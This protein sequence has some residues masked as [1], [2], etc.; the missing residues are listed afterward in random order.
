MLKHGVAFAEAATCFQDQQALIL[1]DSAEGEARWS[2]LGFSDRARLLT[3]IFTAR[4]D[5]PRLISAR[6]A[7][8]RER[9]TY[10]RRV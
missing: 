3:V 9:D 1:E 2:L 6:K 4:G 8:A 5:K 10:A 7:T